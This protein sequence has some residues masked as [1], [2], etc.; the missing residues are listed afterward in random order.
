MM[1]GHFLLALASLYPSNA[2]SLNEIKS[3]LQVIAKVE[4]QACARMAQNYALMIAPPSGHGLLK[5]PQSGPQ[6]KGQAVD[7]ADL[8][9][10]APTAK[11]TPFAQAY[12]SAYEKC[13]ATKG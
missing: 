7:P 12:R 8:I 4:D 5:P 2:L 10:S 3:Q 1:R 9:K 13:L 11:G 6:R